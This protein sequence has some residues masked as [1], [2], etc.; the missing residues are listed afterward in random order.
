MKKILA[1]LF[2]IV[3]LPL[4]DFAGSTSRTGPTPFASVAL[5]GH[6]NAGAWCECGTPG[7]IC[8][9]GEFQGLRRAAPTPTQP[10]NQNPVDRT[11]SS[12][13]DLGSGMLAFALALLL[14]FRM[15]R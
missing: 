12:G 7:C 9:P 3:V 10:V 13:A 6:T 15:R 11:S 4:F 14:W 8:G 5:A 1:C 2:L